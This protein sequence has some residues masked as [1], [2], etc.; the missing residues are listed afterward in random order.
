MSAKHR[1]TKIHYSAAEA[2]GAHVDSPIVHKAVAWFKKKHGQK[3][4]G[5]WQKERPGWALMTGVIGIVKF[6]ADG[7]PEAVRVPGYLSGDFVKLDA[8]GLDYW[9]DDK[10]V[11][12]WWSEPIEM[13]PLPDETT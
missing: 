9:L 8:W 13:P 7:P 12:W 5:H 10:D 11:A 2:I 1:L 6:H 3:E 4:S